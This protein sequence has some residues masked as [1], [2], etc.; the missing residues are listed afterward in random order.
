MGVRQSALIPVN[1][2]S[3]CD[4]GRASVWWASVDGSHATKAILH[5]HRDVAILG[6]T[7]LRE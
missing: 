7:G 5:V 2:G 1:D 6:L 3:V 4:R